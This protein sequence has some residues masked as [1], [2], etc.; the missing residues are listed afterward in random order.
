MLGADNLL[1]RYGKCLEGTVMIRCILTTHAAWQHPPDRLTGIERF[2]L[3]EQQR[4]NRYQRPQDKQA[5]LIGRLLLADLAAEVLGLSDATELSFE[6]DKA[7]RPYI[8]TPAQRPIDVNLSHSGTYVAA[9]VSTVG[10]IGVDVEIE[11]PVHSGVAER[12]FAPAELDLLRNT[13]ATMR[14]SRFFQLWTLKEAYIKAV[15]GGLALQ[16]KRISFDLG[17]DTIR[18]TVLDAPQEATRWHVRSWNPAPTV[19]LAVCAEHAEPP[20]TYEELL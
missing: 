17:G 14:R 13:P 7:D 8:I 12:C 10:R 11:R 18:V 1:S 6:R 16:L 3:D 9:A 5:A 19:W 2:R 4:I 15:G 20:L